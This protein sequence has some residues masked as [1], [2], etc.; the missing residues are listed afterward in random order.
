MHRIGYLG[1]LPFETVDSSSPEHSQKSPSE[2]SIVKKQYSRFPIG[3][4]SQT[5]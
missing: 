5:K 1:M 2:S 4:L 3:K